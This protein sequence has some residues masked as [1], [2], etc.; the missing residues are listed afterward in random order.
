MALIESAIASLSVTPT[1]I[2]VVVPTTTIAT[3]D[4][5]MTPPP[6]PVAFKGFMTF[7]T[8]QS[9]LGNLLA[10]DS[11]SLASLRFA[12]RKVIHPPTVE[13]HCPYSMDV[14]GMFNANPSLFAC[15]ADPLP[16][17][18]S[19]L[20]IDAFD[21]HHLGHCQSCRDTGAIHPCC[22]YATL[23]LC[24]THGFTGA[25]RPD[26]SGVPIPNYVGHGVNGNHSSLDSFA[27]FERAQVTKLLA[28]NK[29][30]TASS[31]ICKNP[32]G[33]NVPRA[34]WQQALTLTGIQAN[35]DHSYIAASEKL[36]KMSDLTYLLKRRMIFDQSASGVNDLFQTERFHYSSIDDVLKHVIPGCYM[37][38]CDVEAYYHNFGLATSIRD[39]FGFTSRDHGDLVF[40]VFPFTGVLPPSWHL[41]LLLRLPLLYVHKVLRLKQ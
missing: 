8:I 10:N 23:R 33:V 41:Q 26:S 40:N 28:Q 20:H 21:Q 4:I 32:L 15:G 14:R 12:Q 39:L 35:D 9:F 5:T 18:E 16:M 2:P 13:D 6:P 34:R 3:T 1:A 17:G 22:Y 38:V 24:L 7:R 31:T 30:S 37:S 19:T 29:V 11:F 25:F 27:L 36:A